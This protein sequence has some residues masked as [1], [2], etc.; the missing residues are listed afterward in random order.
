MANTI[1]TG[2]EDATP[3]QREQISSEKRQEEEDESCIPLSNQRQ[4][5][6]ESNQLGSRKNKS[7]RVE[8]DGES[9]PGKKYAWYMTLSI[10]GTTSQQGT[11]IQKGWTKTIYPK[12]D[13]QAIARESGKAEKTERISAMSRLG[14]SPSQS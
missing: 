13:S 9:H 1:K 14:K 6:R 12:T 3:S 7:V 2:R 5:A 8:D 4:V 11:H 10:P